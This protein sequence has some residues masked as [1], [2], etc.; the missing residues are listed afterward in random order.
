[1]CVVR[2]LATC[3][4][5]LGVTRFGRDETLVISSCALSVSS[6]LPLLSRTGS[7]FTSNVLTSTSNFGQAQG[8]G[9]RVWY[10]SSGDGSGSIVE[11]T[12]SR[13]DANQLVAA[14]FATGGG[15]YVLYFG[16]TSG[17]RVAVAG[18]CLSSSVLLFVYV[19]DALWMCL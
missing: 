11:V 7:S 6:T 12:D 8:G 1:M 10:S 13:F 5:V 16:M 17:A 4:R 9:L 3:I 14:V 19:V 18:A 2:A 15:V